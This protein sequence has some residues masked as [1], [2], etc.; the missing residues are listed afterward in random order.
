MLEAWFKFKAH[1]KSTAISTSATS[2]VA[3]YNAAKAEETSKTKR[4][5][6]SSKG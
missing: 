2:F 3:G 4:V 5:K 6:T 1:A